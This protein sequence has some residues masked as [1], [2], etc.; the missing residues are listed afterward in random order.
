MN[1]P[2]IKAIQQSTD[3]RKLQTL[4]GICSG[5]SAD[6]VLNDKEI[7]YL[8]AWLIDNKSIID[9]WPANVI[10]KRIETIKKDGVIT[11]D[12][13]S[14]LIAL[15]QEISGNTFS[16]T[17]A[18]THEVAGIEYE[19]DPDIVFTNT[20]YCFTGE[21]IFGT[22]A[23]C[24]RTILNLGAMAVSNVSGNLDYLVVG[25]RISENWINT[26]Y[27]RKIEKAIQLK[28]NGSNLAIISEK[29]WIDAITDF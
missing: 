4:L 13:R 25:S 15:L 9:V 28:T 21:F 10:Y 18:V 12:E 16:S 23:K 7:S 2:T 17:G 6:S 29:Q 5:L 19:T 8:H 22:R 26:S 14:N 20:L 27:G 3:T 1:I 24:E 11:D